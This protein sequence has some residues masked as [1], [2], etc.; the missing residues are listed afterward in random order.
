MKYLRIINEEIQYPYILGVLRNEYLNT[1]FPGDINLISLED[2][3]IHLVNEIEIPSD[4]NFT[5][6]IREELPVLI[7]GNYYQNWIVE[8]APIEY[9][10]L[11][12][13]NS[14]DLTWS[15]IRSM[16]NQYLAETDWTQLFDSPLIGEVKENW[17]HY[18]QSLRDITDQED[19]FNI[20]WPTKP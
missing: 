15:Q 9:T 6:L 5:K 3:D 11:L 19:P 14:K 13:Q 7:D 20:I 4:E 10:E 16:R 2:Y 17:I 12:I 1:S 18:R 8:D